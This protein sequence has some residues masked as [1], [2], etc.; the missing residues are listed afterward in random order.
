VSLNFSQRFPWAFRLVE[1]L[2]IA[3]HDRVNERI[4]AP[5][6][7]LGFLAPPSDLIWC[8]RKDIHEV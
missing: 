1:Q 2:T 5:N 7:G 4:E 6:S 8:M 3:S